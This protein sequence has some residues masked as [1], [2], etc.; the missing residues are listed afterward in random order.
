MRNGEAGSYDFDP[1]LPQL[2]DAFD[3]QAVARRFEAQWPA[4]NAGQA[5]VQI[6]RCRIQD[7]KYQPGSRS[8]VVYDLGFVSSDGAGQ[9]IGVVEVTPHGLRHRLYTS[10]AALPTLPAA[11]DADA[12][13][14]RFAALLDDNV[15]H[16][17]IT[18]V[19]YKPG[20]RCVF[21]YDLHMSH[22]PY[23]V[24]GKLLRDGGTDLATTI[25]QLHA[26]TA[27]ILSLPRVLKP[28]VFWPDL[29]ML[30]QPAVAGGVELNARAFDMAEP[31]AQREAWLT[32]TGSYL[33]ALHTLADV[34]GPQR[35]F[36][37]DLAELRSYSAA[38]A[39]AAPEIAARFDGGVAS[40]AARGDGLAAPR[41]VA[42]HGAFRTDQFML[43]NG[44]FVLI[45]LDGFCWANPGRDPGN[46][47]AY[48][49]WKAIRQ[50]RQTDWIVRAGQLFCAGY[51]AAGAQIDEGWLALY[52]AASLLKIVGR[53]F[54]S[55]TIREWPLIPA[56]LDAA[57]TRIDQA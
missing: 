9:T 1:A 52:E 53:R 16:C 15:T 3:L 17:T 37:D 11:V 27:T 45:D 6:T 51:A 56:L 42:S 48:L 40:L 20:A 30:I 19:R 43:D 32:A 49:R 7:T 26:R 29:Q 41:I 54:R 10:D 4:W 35:T 14:A 2:A 18:P 24:F 57:L 25:E 8:V 38:I 22:G 23:V 36:A 31:L 34:A 33:A 39:Q 5:S 47:L 21:R 28:L 55:L 46:F 13:R 44:Q 50:P 12:M